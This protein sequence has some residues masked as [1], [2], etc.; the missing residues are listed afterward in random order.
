MSGK[1]SSEN[2][3][4]ELNRRDMLLG[5]TA[6]AAATAVLASSAA[7]QKA[8]AQPADGKKVIL[9]SDNKPSESPSCPAC[10]GAAPKLEKIAQSK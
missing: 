6:L 8:S 5:G 7:V 10:A 9:A 3:G 1:T 2:S 4:P